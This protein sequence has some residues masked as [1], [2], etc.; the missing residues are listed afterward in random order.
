M[1]IRLYTFSANSRLVHSSSSGC[2]CCSYLTFLPP[3]WYISSFT[4]N[5]MHRRVSLLVYDT[6]RWILPSTCHSVGF[7]STTIKEAISAKK[8]V[9]TKRFQGLPQLDNFSLEKEELPELKPGDVLCE[10][11]Y[12]SVDPYMRPYSLSWPL[13]TTMKGG[14][15]SKVIESKNEK[16]P[17]GSLLVGYFGW[18]T[19]TVVN[20]DVRSKDF[21]EQITV[22]PNL[23]TLCPSVGLGAVGMPGNSAYFGFLEICKPKHGD[24]V[25]VSGAAGAVGSLVGQIAKIKGC[26]VIGFAGSD[27]KVK[28]LTDELGFDNAYNYKTC[29]WKSSLKEGAPN[30]VDCY[31]DNVGGQLSVA[32]RSHMNDFGRISVC[33]AISLYNDTVPTLVPCVEPAMVFKQLRMEGFLV[34]RWTHRFLEGMGQMSTWIQEGKIK[35]KE[36]HTNGFENMPAAF[37]DMLKGGNFGKAIV[38]A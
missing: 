9:F 32:V 26:H 25:V 4:S 15:V 7:H 6:C 13:G 17:V 3:S 14:Q 22:L 33:G 34:H 21:M 23:G 5:K 37:I 19:H 29:D 38:K 12:L 8:F 20:P 27:E 36:T 24:V 16:F 1:A 18:R 30:G 2:I 28:W 31:F 11:L 35:I 10:A